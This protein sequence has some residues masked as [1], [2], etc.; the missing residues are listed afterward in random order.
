MFV[1]GVG[2][3]ESVALAY[4]LLIDGY[5]RKEADVVPFPPRLY[6]NGYVSMRLVTLLSRSS[7]HRPL[8]LVMTSPIYVQYLV[9]YR[10]T[11]SS[12]STYL[13]TARA[14]IGME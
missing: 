10:I 4:S 12:P 13:P 14:R 6:L 2:K 9:R 7:S 1:L 8:A 11:E 3:S 5:S